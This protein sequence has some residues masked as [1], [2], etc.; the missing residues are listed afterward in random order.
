MWAPATAPASSFEDDV[1]G[2]L[3]REPD[4]GQ[5][6]E[7]REPR[8]GGL[9]LVVGDAGRLLAVRVGV[10]LLGAHAVPP[11]SWWVRLATQS[12]SRTGVG[13]RVSVAGARMMRQLVRGAVDGVGQDGRRP[14]GRR[15]PGPTPR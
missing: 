4:G 13:A 5:G 6:L 9:V 10:V 2:L 14:G 11:V 7:D 15:R 1:V 8:V 12:G 3:V